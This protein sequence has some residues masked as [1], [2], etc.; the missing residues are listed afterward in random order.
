MCCSSQGQSL[1]LHACLAQESG[2]QGRVRTLS[3]RRHRHSAIT[4][5]PG[6]QNCHLVND[7]VL[8]IKN[9]GA[10]SRES[11]WSQ[12]WLWQTHPLNVKPSQIVVSQTIFSL[13]FPSFDDLDLICN[14]EFH[15]ITSL[16]CGRN[17]QTPLC[18][19]KE[20]QA[21]PVRQSV[22]PRKEK[23]QGQS[24]SG[25]KGLFSNITLSCDL[26]KE[27]FPVASAQLF[28]TLASSNGNHEAPNG[29][30]ILSMLP[31]TARSL[32]VGP[33][34]LMR[35]KGCCQCYEYLIIG[36]GVTNLAVGVD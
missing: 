28:G 21:P 29:F 27:T 2:P 20:R 12:F 32:A 19:A 5:A 17:P 13:S 35:G 31:D 3:F 14:L 11:I 8:R 34:I 26:K 1:I 24:F 30:L 9:Q 15:Y 33:I 25:D 16:C 22:L 23:G 10:E 7:S 6:T 4:S 36:K 18:P